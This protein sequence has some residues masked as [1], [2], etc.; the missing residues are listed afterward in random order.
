MISVK[1]SEIISEKTFVK[2]HH[3]DV[4][5]FYASILS[6]QEQFRL[7]QRCV[8]RPGNRKERQRQPTQKTKSKPQLLHPAGLKKDVR[9]PDQTPEIIH[10]TALQQD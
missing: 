8:R 9:K 10:Q 1:T 5:G 4:G 3:S 7:L 6:L 2:L